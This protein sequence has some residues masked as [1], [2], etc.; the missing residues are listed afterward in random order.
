M[1]EVDFAA[2]VA[3]AGGVEYPLSPLGP[4]AQDLVL[5]GG[6]EALVRDRISAS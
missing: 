5:A 2:S 1:V 6:L 3:R 4:A